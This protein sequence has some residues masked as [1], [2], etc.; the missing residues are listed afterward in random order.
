MKLTRRIIAEGCWMTE[1]ETCHVTHIL[2]P[3]NKEDEI[4]RAQGWTSCI[5]FSI[6]LFGTGQKLAVC[7]GQNQAISNLP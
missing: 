4:C 7:H 5:I 6:L 2:V 1:T 3:K